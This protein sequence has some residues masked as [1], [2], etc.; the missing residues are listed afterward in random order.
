MTEDLHLHRRRT[1]R[2]PSPFVQLLRTYWVEVAIG[3][4]L[5]LT[6]FLFFER[7]NI[8][9]SIFAWL[10]RLDDAL[11]S[12]VGRAIETLMRFRASL[13]LSETIAIPLFLVLLVAIVWRVRW[14][15]QRTPSLVSLTCPRCGGRIHRSHRH[16]TD[17][18]I[19][20]FVPVRRY[21]CAT[22]ECRWHGLRIEGVGRQPHPLA[23]PEEQPPQHAAP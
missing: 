2:R 1:K 22:K 11:M 18:L 7:L 3:V 12:F 5:L 10:N 14:R 13:G 9:A 21:R 17:R 8:R 19:S 16:A 15:L 4:G 23:A 6:V 20:L